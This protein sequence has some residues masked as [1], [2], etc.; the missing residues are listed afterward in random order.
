VALVS[1]NVLMFALEFAWG[2]W[3]SPPTLYRM[4]AGLGRAGLV[5]E[6]WRIVSAAFLHFSVAHLCFNMWALLAFGQMLE[7]ILGAR[8]LL[9]LYAVSAAAGGLA[10][11]VFHAQVVSAGASGA[12]WGLMTGQIALVVRLRQ[13]RGPGGVP[14]RMSS[15]LQPLVVNLLYSLTPGI[16]MAAHLGGGVAGAGLILSGLIGWTRPEPA[17]WRRAAWGASL[18]M[19]ACIALALGH[20]RPWELLWPPSLVPRAIA[21]TPVIVPVPRGLQPAP[22]AEG[23]FWVFGDLSVDPLAVYCA[24]GKLEGTLV[25][26]DLSDALTQMAHEE[27][28]RRLEKNQSW[29]QEPR[30]VQLHQRRAVFSATHFRDAGRIQTW[31]MAEGSWWIRLDVMQRPD[32]PKS[33][34]TLPAAISEGISIVPRTSPR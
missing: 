16:D 28:A 5:R 8:R 4:G 18:G 12:V 2:G 11:A 29:D 17:I 1:V 32:A 22:K 27:A 21:G 14:V 13:Q 10:S 30:L 6:P 15:L 31:L 3:D 25:G 19:A 26:Q 7:V 23:G 9:V 24:T 33:W 20:G 34:A